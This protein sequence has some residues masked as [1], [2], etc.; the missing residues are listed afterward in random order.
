M[1]TFEIIAHNHELTGQFFH[2]LL[3]WDD[4]AISCGDD[5]IF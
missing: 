5:A 1:Q 2:C 4:L 3:E